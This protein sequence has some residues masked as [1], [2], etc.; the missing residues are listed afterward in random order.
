MYLLPWGSALCWSIA[1]TVEE[2]IQADGVIVGMC[3]PIWKLW[4][5]DRRLLL[6]FLSPREKL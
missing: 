6:A 3:C 4:F 2:L 5:W 1:E